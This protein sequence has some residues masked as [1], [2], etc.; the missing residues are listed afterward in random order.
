MYHSFLIHSSADERL[1]CF[2]VL[3]VINLMLPYTSVFPH[4]PGSSRGS[5]LFM[6]LP[7]WLHVKESACQCRKCGFNLWV[8][9]IPCRRKWQSSLVFLPGKSYGQMSLA[10]YSPWCRKSKRV[11]HNL[12]T[13]QTFISFSIPITWPQVW[14]LKVLSFSLCF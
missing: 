14:R 11:R 8:G 5:L 1:G 12:V 3:A 2:H 4:W 7:R 9:K 13:K 10:G 6:D